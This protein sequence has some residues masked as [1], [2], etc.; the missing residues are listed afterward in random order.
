MAGF[1]V[2]RLLKLFGEVPEAVHQRVKGVMERYFVN[3]AADVAVKV[4]LAP[5]VAVAPSGQLRH[6]VSDGC[7]RGK[8]DLRVEAAGKALGPEA[9]IL[10]LR[11]EV[12]LDEPP[13]GVQRDDLLRGDVDVGACHGKPV[14]A[15]AAVPDE[16]NAHRDRIISRRHDVDDADDVVA[17]AVLHAC[18]YGFEQPAK[19]VLFAVPQAVLLALPEHAD[20]IEAEIFHSP[21]KA[22][23]CE[24]RIDEH[25]I[26]RKP[27]LEAAFEHVDCQIKLGAHGVFAPFAA[28][29]A[30]VYRKVDP[31]DA[32]RLLCRGDRVKRKLDVAERIAPPGLQ[33]REAAH[34]AA[35]DVVERPRQQ[36]DVFA[37]GSL[38]R[39]VVNHEAELPGRIGELRDLAGD[40]CGGQKHELCP[41]VERAGDEAVKGAL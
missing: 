21:D 25:V 27:C 10:L 20:H 23:A 31:A 14:P 32:E 33:Q 4:A 30:H 41:V 7:G 8:S 37:P 36:L 35:G 19:V 16:H 17:A 5:L 13:A 29:G 24:P 9:E 3:L 34:A 12:R 40:L 6:H 11:P 2:S 15:V 28:A 38:N 18:G 1:Q 26:D 22:A 39:G